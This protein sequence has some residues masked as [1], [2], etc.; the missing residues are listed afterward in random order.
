MESEDEPIFA[1]GIIVRRDLKDVLP[2]ADGLRAA[3]WW[4]PPAARSACDDALEGGC[5]EKQDSCVDH[6][7]GD[8]ISVSE[9]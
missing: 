7:D 3:R 4:A 8:L 5:K 9:R 1:L 6:H 2:A